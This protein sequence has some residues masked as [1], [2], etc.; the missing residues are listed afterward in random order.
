[1]PRPQEIV[2]NTGPI[3]AL[4]AALDDLAILKSLYRKVHVPYEVGVEIMASGANGFAVSQYEQADWLEK[5]TQPTDF[6]PLLQNTLDIGEASVV[7]LALNQGIKTVCIDES[8]GRRVAR[9][10]GLSLT[11]SLGILLRAKQEGYPLHMKEVIQRMKQKGIWLSDGLVTSAL[12]HAG[13]L[14]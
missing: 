3:I 14:E 12:K 13:E 8:V 7:Q 1:M 2:I 5:W 11:G 10:S 9:L 6:I 4:V